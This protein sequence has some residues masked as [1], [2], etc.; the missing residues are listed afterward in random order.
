MKKLLEKQVVFTW[1]LRILAAWSKKPWTDRWIPG[2]TRRLARLNVLL[3]R[4]QPT[5]EAKELAQTWVDLMPPDGKENFQIK[6]VEGDTAYVEIHL[7]CPLRATGDVRACHRL[8]NYDRNLMKAVGGQLIVLESQ[9]NSGKSFCR[10][11]IRKAGLSVDD[12]PA[13]YMESE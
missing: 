12:L 8:M 13:A 6:S 2:T 7:H 11:A 5:S 3:N 4:P 10:L 9:S 1:V